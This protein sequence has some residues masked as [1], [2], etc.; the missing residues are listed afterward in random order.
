MIR[1]PIGLV[2]F[3]AFIVF[4][5]AAIRKKTQGARLIMADAYPLSIPLFTEARYGVNWGE[6]KTIENAPTL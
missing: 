3:R 5:R 6:M 1:P 2:A 4:V